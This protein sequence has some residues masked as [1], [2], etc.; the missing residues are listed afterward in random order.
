MT[1]PAKW[2]C[3]CMVSIGNKDRPCPEHR[4]DP[5]QAK[6]EEIIRTVSGYGSP[7]RQRQ[8]QL[9]R[10]AHRGD[11]AVTRQEVQDHLMKYKSECGSLR[12]AAKLLG[13]SAAYYCDILKRRRGLG[14]KILKALDLKKVVVV[15]VSYER[16]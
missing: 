5:D 3:N 4:P 1:N 9:H 12:Q 6:A 7:R 2:K 10:P 15:T 13:I 8:G 11:G 14:P 16:A